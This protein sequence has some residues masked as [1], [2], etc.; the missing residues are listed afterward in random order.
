[1]RR[2]FTPLLVALL[3]LSA[4]ASAS[5]TTL[6]PGF[7][8]STVWS[9]LGTPTVFRFAPD[10]RV[11]V[12]TKSGLIYEFASVDDPTPTVFADLRQETF[13]A[14]D[15]GMLGLALD[16]KFDSGRPYLYVL[17]D[18][19]K[20]P[21]GTTVPGWGDTCPTPPGPTTNGCA[22]TGRLSRLDAA[23]GETVL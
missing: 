2:T 18:Y 15:R 22:I 7:A 6:P 19:D 3:V 14:W 1:M 23:G 9:G 10:G 17:Y 5:E 13:D 8:E 16:P 12:A 20:A 21:G 11:F 4:D